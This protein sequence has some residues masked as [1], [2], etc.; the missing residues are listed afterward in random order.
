M[1]KFAVLK[2]SFEL[3]TKKWEGII[4]EKE[5]VDEYLIGGSMDEQL[6]AEFDS[7][8]EARAE[9]KNIC[10]S[11]DK[12]ETYVK[13]PGRRTYDCHLAI[14]QEREYDEETG[15]YEIIEWWDILAEE[16]IL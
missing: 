12:I 9:F 3:N 1:K 8:D 4:T 5:V 6:V 13:V 15:D 10:V 7:L 16:I 2:D 14:I 11:S